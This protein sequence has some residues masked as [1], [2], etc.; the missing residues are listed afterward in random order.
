MNSSAGKHFLSHDSWGCDDTESWGNDHH[1]TETCGHEQHQQDVQHGH[2]ERDKRRAPHLDIQCAHAQACASCQ[3]A[4]PSAQPSTVKS[5][6]QIHDQD[7]SCRD[8]GGDVGGG[9]GGRH[10]A[11]P[12]TTTTFTQDAG[13]RCSS[14]SDSEPLPTMPPLLPGCSL[15]LSLSLMPHTLARI[16]LSHAA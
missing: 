6:H 11:P 1:H 9:A 12:S 2:D 4:P 3:D 13:M 8:G 5:K 16:S 15:S 10:G 14:L 7:K